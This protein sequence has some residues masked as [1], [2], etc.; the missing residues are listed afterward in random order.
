MSNSTTLAAAGG[1][2][3]GAAAAPV[4]SAIMPGW[5]TPE[6]VCAGVEEPA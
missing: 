3:L 4:P 2:V 6:G 5:A 1:F